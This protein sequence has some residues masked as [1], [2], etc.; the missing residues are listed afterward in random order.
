MGCICWAILLFFLIG[1]GIRTLVKGRI[2]ATSTRSVQGVPAYI[3]GVLLIVSLPLS[4]IVTVGYLVIF[5]AT[6][7]TK[8][9]NRDAL[10]GPAFV[11]MAASFL[12]TLLFAAI[13]GLLTAKKDEPKRRTPQFDDDYASRFDDERRRRPRR[14]RDEDWDSAGEE[15]PPE[16]DDRGRY[17]EGR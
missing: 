16:D 10:T 9:Q 7:P 1:G 5:L 2:K 3:I 14:G 15:E 13:L 8:L 11:V 17:R 12:G 6:D 4:F